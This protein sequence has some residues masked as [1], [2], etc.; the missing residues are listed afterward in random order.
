MDGI[1]VSQ[2]PYKRRRR[3]LQHLAQRHQ[4][5]AAEKTKRIKVSFVFYDTK[6]T[7]ILD[8]YY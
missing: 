5:L 4:C 1:G 3:L 7:L 8:D 6:L 2:S